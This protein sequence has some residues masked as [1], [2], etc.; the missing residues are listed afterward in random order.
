MNAVASF[1]SEYIFLYI[2]LITT[3]FINIMAPTSGSMIINPVTA[4]FTDPQRAIG[5]GAFI[6][7]ITGLH[8]VYLFRKEIFQ[9]KKNVKTIKTMLPF[10][11]LGA[12]VGGTLISYLNAKL[13]AGI[14]IVASCF[15]VF[16]TLRRLSVT[17]EHK[18]GSKK[19]LISVAFLS[20]FLQGGG[21]S[22]ADLRNNYLRSIVSE[23]SVRAV[24]SA[25]GLMVFFI[26]GTI[27]FFHNFLKSSDVILILTLIPFLIFAQIY[28]KKFLHK[29][30]DRNAK[31][32]SIALSLVGIAL[33]A[34]KYFL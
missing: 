29:M 6:F 34:Y 3:T 32:L 18:E 4:F 20:G 22:G 26:T 25:T 19:S 1:I 5:I 11:A 16:K 24:G 27:I 14:V 10:S 12:V 21:L 13:L 2:W 7:F 9:D 15:F 31:I 28:G 8:R 30:K 33:L 23:V 17:I